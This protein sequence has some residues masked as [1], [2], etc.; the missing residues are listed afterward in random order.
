MQCFLY[1]ILFRPFYPEKKK[2]KLSFPSIEDALSPLHMKLQ[3]V[4]FQRCECV[5]ACLITLS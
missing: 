1:P 3:V 5:F 4:K 2:N